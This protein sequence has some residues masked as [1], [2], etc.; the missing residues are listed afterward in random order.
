MEIMHHTEA[1]HKVV[2]ADDCKEGAL[3]QKNNSFPRVC[4]VTSA[5]TS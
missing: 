3:S 2:E 1:Y 5:Q 4:I